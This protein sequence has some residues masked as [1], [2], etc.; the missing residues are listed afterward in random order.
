[1]NTA[2]SIATALVLMVGSVPAE[3]ATVSAQSSQS[4]DGGAADNSRFD[5]F[6]PQEQGSKV[7]LD[8]SIWDAALDS[9]VISLGPSLRTAPPTLRHLMGTHLRRGHNS[10]YRLEGN[11]IIF[12]YLNADVIASLTEYRQDLERIGTDIGIAGLPRNE[13]LAF[14]LNLHNVAIIEQ[15]ALAYPTMRPSDVKIDGVPLDKAAFIE[16]A[17]I[18]LSPNDIRTQIVY[19]NWSD[20]RVMYGFFR[21]DIGSPAIQADPFTAFNLSDLLDR[22]AKEFVNSLR[23]T[24]R[25]GDT[26]HVSQIYEEA[27]SFYFR[28]FSKDMLAHLGKFAEAEVREDLARVSSARA[29]IYEPDIADL[30][31]GQKLANYGNVSSSDGVG[32][33]IRIPLLVQI[34][35]KE[36]ADKIIKLSREGKYIRSVRILPIILPGEEL[37]IDEVE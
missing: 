31:R 9:F 35:A 30:S 1:M 10:F 11:R 4:L 26:M 3:A 8:Y 23:G 15:V 28:D 19:P 21:G 13:Q 7:S 33:S 37:R 36:R 27:S 34:F 32:S 25:R 22:S 6:A 18:K 2:R 24:E 5:R 12:E 17:G 14:W 16:I 29:T 20:P